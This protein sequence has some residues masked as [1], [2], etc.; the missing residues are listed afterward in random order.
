[1]DATDDEP[2]PG[3]IYMD[4]MHFG[5]GNSSLQITYETQNVNHAKYLYDMLVAFTPVMSALSLNAPIYK[6]KLSAHDF[7]WQSIEQSV[8]CRTKDERNP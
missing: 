7:R 2:Y 1:M 4:A 3:F 8:D 5:M 6:G